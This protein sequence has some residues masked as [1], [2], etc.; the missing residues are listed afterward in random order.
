MTVFKDIFASD[1]G[2][3]RSRRASL[4][5][6]RAGSTINVSGGSVNFASGYIDTTKLTYNGTLTD[7]GS[8]LTTMYAHQTSAYVKSGQT[9]K[10]GQTIGTVGSTGWS[11]GPHLHYEVRI[12]GTAYDPRG[13]YGASKRKVNC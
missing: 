10:A 2:L 6:Q 7:I 12:D 3:L 13:W 11:T 1:A 5:I 4:P 9:V 8:G